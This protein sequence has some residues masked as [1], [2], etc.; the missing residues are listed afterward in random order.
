M[1]KPALDSVLLH[2]FLAR[3]RHI[4]LS[5]SLLLFCHCSRKIY[6]IVPLLFSTQLLRFN[7]LTMFLNKEKKCKLKHL[8][9]K[10]HLSP[11]YDTNKIK[12]YEQRN[13]PAFQKALLSTISCISCFNWCN[14]YIL[15]CRNL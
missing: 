1:T 13:S 7:A 6:P 10:L 3:T 15:Y 4:F 12:V 5:L 11:P 9:K 14:G 2:F 8:G